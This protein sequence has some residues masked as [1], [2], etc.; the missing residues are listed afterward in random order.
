MEGSTQQDQMIDFYAKLFYMNFQGENKDQL[1]NMI[2]A[3]RNFCSCFKDTAYEIK[4]LQDLYANPILFVLTNFKEH[5][6]DKQASRISIKKT[7]S[8]LEWI[9][10]RDTKRNCSLRREYHVDDNK[11]TRV[12]HLNLA[13]IIA[14]RG[15]IK[16]AV[17]DIFTDVAIRN[18]VK[19]DPMLLP[20]LMNE[21]IKQVGVED[22]ER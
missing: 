6:S 19:L 11:P 5:F 14:L 20:N 21:P 12:K 16:M 8:Q 2:H 3:V 10:F 22:F 9:Y 1:S 17:G 7:V 4:Q 15:F 13:D 18:S